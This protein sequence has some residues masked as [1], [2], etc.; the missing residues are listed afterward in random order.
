MNYKIIKIKFIVIRYLVLIMFV[1][2]I[3]AIIFLINGF[4]EQKPV[5]RIIINFQERGEFQNTITYQNQKVNIYKVQPKWEYEDVTNPVFTI[6]DKG[7][8]YIGS[9]LDI[10]LTNRNPLRT[11]PSA[12]VRDFGEFFSKEFFIGHATINTTDDGKQMIESVGNVSEYNGVREKEN[13][14]LQTEINFENDAQIIVGLRIKGVSNETK[15][16]IIESLREKIGLKYN[17]LF[18]VPMNNSYYCTDLITRTLNDFNINIDY[19]RLYPT[20]SDI[21]ISDKTYPIFIC[22]RIENGVFNIYYLGE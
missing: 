5:E 18:V 16:Q 6:D 17:W 15:D 21:I 1:L 8:Y 4:M 13:D 14:W 9:K 22:E 12:I 2:F 7:D 19:D 10:I 3:C 11:E 20:G